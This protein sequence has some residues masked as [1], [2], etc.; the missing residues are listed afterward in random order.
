MKKSILLLPPAVIL[1][2]VIFQ[3]ATRDRTT[4]PARET[5]ASA[6]K[7]SL[8]DD[9]RSSTPRIDWAKAAAAM[10][11]ASPSGQIDE[12][13]DY[14]QFLK[15][16]AAMSGPQLVAAWEELAAT[17]LPAE[18]K[19]RFESHLM[20]TLVRKDVELALA[21]FASDLGNPADQTGTMLLS[22]FREWAVRSPIKAELWLD[23]RIQ[24][25]TFD[26]GVEVNGTPVRVLYERELIRS[27]LLTGPD[28]VAARL[29]ALPESSRPMA[30]KG[31]DSAQVQRAYATL[32]RKYFPQAEQ[33]AE[34]RRMAV[35]A[36]YLEGPDGVANLL[37]RI[38]ATPAE[39][40]WILRP[41]P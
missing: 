35:A 18:A 11:Q 1:G 40:D 34:F 31:T 15:E 39:R 7:T 6:T 33:L 17:D 21:H 9:A 12:T 29:D 23:A 32:V 38:A 37:D 36:R 14:G 3:Q 5:P 28:K 2:L 24:D 8:R 10:N 20:S 30:L 25:G 41:S 4:E 26:D 19:T 22:G 27:L 13:S 16:V